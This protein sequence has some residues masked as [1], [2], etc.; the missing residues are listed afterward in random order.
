MECRAAAAAAAAVGPADALD[1]LVSGLRFFTALLALE[2]L[3]C[4]AGRPLVGRFFPLLC[5]CGR[6]DTEGFTRGAAFFAASLASSA[7]C[8]AA[9]ALFRRFAAFDAAF[10]AAFAFAAA[11]ALAVERAEA[12]CAGFTAVLVSAALV[13]RGRGAGRAVRL[14]AFGRVGRRTGLTKA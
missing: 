5:L 1:G 4:F 7:A 14:G 2:C 10:L 12:A 6:R 13:G 3:L 11:L 8:A 9:A